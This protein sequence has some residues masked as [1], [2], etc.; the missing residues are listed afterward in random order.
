MRGGGAGED[1]DNI[2]NTDFAYPTKTVGISQNRKG[3]GIR[4]FWKSTLNPGAVAWVGQRSR[5]GRL[6]SVR[7][8][9][10]R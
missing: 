3:P 1:Y 9:K 2:C 10:L 8:E 7:R 4:V 5:G 6:P